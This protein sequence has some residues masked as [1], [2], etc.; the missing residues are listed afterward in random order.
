MVT[1]PTRA[2]K[3]GISSPLLVPAVAICDP[4]MTLGCPPTV[5]GFSGI[6][7]LVHAVEAFCAPVRANPWEDYPGDVFRGADPLS[8]YHCLPAIEL[9]GG[10]LEAPM[11]MVP[12]SGPGRR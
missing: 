12:T 5:T 6:D 8:R 11:R 1:D 3:V 7:A 2:L 4:V 10:A 9:I